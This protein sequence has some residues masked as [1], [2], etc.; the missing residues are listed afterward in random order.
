MKVRYLER[1]K[2]TKYLQK[3]QKDQKWGITKKN[4]LFEGEES[5]SDSG[6]DGTKINI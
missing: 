3:N 6:V 5:G 1:K 4:G 2:Q